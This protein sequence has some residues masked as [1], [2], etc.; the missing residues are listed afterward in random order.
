LTIISS[1]LT[2]G[3]L[4]PLQQ[5]DYGGSANSHSVIRAAQKVT[6]EFRESSGEKF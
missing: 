4:L 5:Y 3:W 1:P 6:E 2:F